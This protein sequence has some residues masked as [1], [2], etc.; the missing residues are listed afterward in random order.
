MGFRVKYF[1]VFF[2]VLVLFIP[3][4]FASSEKSVDQKVREESKKSHFQVPVNYKIDSALDNK[5]SSNTKKE[6][7]KK[8]MYHDQYKKEMS[9]K[10]N[11][12]VISADTHGLHQQRQEEFLQKN[13]QSLNDKKKKKP[14]FLDHVILDLKD[15]PRIK[16][17][18]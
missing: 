7:T 8:V 3:N 18:K 10:K 17:N 4:V 9:D 2:S 16:P 6:V 15:G 14:G 11:I 12:G 1:I 13:F 5:E